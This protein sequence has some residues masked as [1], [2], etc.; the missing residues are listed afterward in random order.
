MTTHETLY[1]IAN[2]IWY[3]PKYLKS[4]L[5]DFEEWNN[6]IAWYFTAI[7][8]SLLYMYSFIFAMIWLFL[9]M[10]I[11]YKYHKTWKK[12]YQSSVCEANWIEF[13]KYYIFK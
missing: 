5:K 2:M 6:F 8:Y 4:A 1:E 12:C 7:I 3:T 10:W 11:F 13:K 9:I